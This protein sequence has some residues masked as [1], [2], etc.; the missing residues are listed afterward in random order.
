MDVCRG[1]REWKISQECSLR[2]NFLPE[3]EANTEKSRPKKWR[4]IDSSQ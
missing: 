4:P 1:K 2:W 3:K